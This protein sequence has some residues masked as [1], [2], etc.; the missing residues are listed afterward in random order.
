MYVDARAINV[1]VNEGI[2][3]LSGTVSSLPEFRAVDEI[4]CRTTGIVT[5]NNE[6]IIE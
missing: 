1:R 2:V 4:A 5:I 3:T 6:V